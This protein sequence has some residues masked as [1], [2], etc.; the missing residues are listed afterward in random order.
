[1]SVKPIK[2][3]F[4]NKKVTAI[5]EPVVEPRAEQ[6]QIE[7]VASEFGKLTITSKRAA[8]FNEFDH[9]FAQFESKINS[10]NVGP[11]QTDD[12][13]GIF[14]TLLYSQMKLGQSLIDVNCSSLSS[15]SKSKV[16]ESLAAT[17]LHVSEKLKQIHSS[18][19]RKKRLLNNPWYVPPQEKSIGLKW[20][21]KESP[22]IPNYVL[23]QTTF[24][25]I[26]IKDTLLS[27]FLKP[28]FKKV[29]FEFNQNKAHKCRENVYENYCCSKVYKRMN[30]GQNEN[31]IIIELGW[32]DIDPCAALKSKSTIHKLTAI[33]FKIRNLPLEFMSKVDCI[34]LVAL[35]ETENTKRGDGI[36]G[37]FELAVKELQELETDGIQIDE[38]T[39]LKVFL[40]NAV[41]DNLGMN[42]ALGFIECFSTDYM[43]R[44][45]EMKKV[46][47]AVATR[48]DQSKLRTELSFQRSIEYIRSL[49]PIES[50]DFKKSKGVKSYPVLNNLRKFTVLQNKN[51]DF[52][53]DVLEG[54]V[55]C[56]IDKFIKFCSEN[57]ICSIK[58][59]QNMIRDFYYGELC[60][61]NR[62]S[63]MGAKS[64]NQ[65][66]MQLY[67]IMV[68]FPFIFKDFQAKFSPELIECMTTLLEIM[69][70]LH[71]TS[72]RESDLVRLESLI[73]RHLTSYQS[74]YNS[75]LTPKHHFLT[76]YPNVIREMGPVIF[77]W[78]MRYEAKNKM[79]TSFTKGGCFKNIA[80]TVA[81]RH[82]L[83][84]CKDQ[85]DVCMF[86]KSRQTK[87]NAS[88]HFTKY[89][90]LLNG[91]NLNDLY[92]LNFLNF[93]HFQYRRGYFL[94]IKSIVHEIIEILTSDDSFY[95]IC[96]Q[97]D[98]VQFDSF[99][100]SIEIIDKNASE[101]FL[102]TF[103]DLENK[104]SY[105][106]KH[107][108]G[109]KYI[110]ADT[111]NVYKPE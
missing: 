55:V 28:S 61:K 59:A 10:L 23:A 38:D 78:M 34:F 104:Q 50:V 40:F 51:V 16:N 74:V 89:E 88:S 102:I 81:E 47:W 110:I 5:N 58:A 15:E 91:F 2:I 20:C 77:T 12:I 17:N 97:Y 46:E 76:H 75:K 57:Q 3:S 73:D 8:V 80:M 79:L 94:I 11:K 70:I 95:F 103:V 54:V 22:D 60:K 14:Q 87:V 9:Q 26:S 6:V 63:K 84:M 42:G 108:Y 65:N 19:K 96:K 32:D 39:N 99:F 107:A 44:F 72:I 109:K 4:K 18:Y 71:S 33:N 67:T 105:E 35:C 13:I 1:M 98:V 29:F 7:N 43:C 111:L 48:E 24:Q 27:L 49:S 62:P 36:N 56:F 106:K 93:C 45:C 92:A 69:Q 30:L 53:H 101:L 86:A 82:Q 83:A 85:F 41:G 31:E 100:N 64:L 52:M 21:T 66:A 37:L 68:H 90:T 25:Y